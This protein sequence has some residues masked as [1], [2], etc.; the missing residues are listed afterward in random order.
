MR[1]IDMTNVQNCMQRY[2]ICAWKMYFWMGFTE[3]QMNSTSLFEDM[4]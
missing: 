2:K 3:H 1:I 4:L